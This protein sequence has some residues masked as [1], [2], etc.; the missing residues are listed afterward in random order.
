VIEFKKSDSDPNAAKWQL[1]L[2]LF[3]LKQKGIE[4][5]GRLEYAEKN[6]QAKTEVVILDDAYEAELLRIFEE[7]DAL[8]AKTTPPSPV[9]TQKCKR[10]AYYEYCFI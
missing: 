5:K 2:E 8:V 3:T 7:I 9:F 6:H 10:C 1:L 4:K